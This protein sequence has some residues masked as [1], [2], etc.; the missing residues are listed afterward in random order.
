MDLY[1]VDVEVLGGKHERMKIKLEVDDKYDTDGDWSAIGEAAALL[2]D[3]DGSWVFDHARSQINTRDI[4]FW[5]S[6]GS[7][8]FNYKIQALR[9]YEVVK[10][11]LGDGTR[12]LLD[13]GIVG[14]G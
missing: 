10:H 12:L 6:K 8:P 7:W 4:T 14:H 2:R 3:V 5:A 11:I 9:F 13:A 1:L